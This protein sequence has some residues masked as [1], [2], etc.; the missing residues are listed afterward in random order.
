MTNFADNLSTH[1][2]PPEPTFRELMLKAYDE[3]R[4][5]TCRYP[6][7]GNDDAIGLEKHMV[8]QAMEAWRD[9]PAPERKIVMASV[10]RNV[11]RT[12]K[13]F[14]QRK[15]S[16]Q[17]MDNMAADVALWLAHELLF[18][19]GEKHLTKGPDREA[20]AKVE[21]LGYHE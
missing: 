11:K 13:R 18:N 10:L 6:Y 17:E 21:E 9:T 16:S 4:L 2:A 3:K 20:F 1:P 5:I 12:V 15:A 14:K 19:D 8:D 7:G